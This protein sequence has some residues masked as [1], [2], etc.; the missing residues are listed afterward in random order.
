MPLAEFQAD[1]PG[2]CGRLRQ[3][4]R[5]RRWGHAYL[6]LGDD[7][8][9]LERFARAWA[10]ACACPSPAADGDACGTCAVCRGLATDGYPDLHLLR[11]RSKSRQIVVDDVREFER[12]LWLTGTTRHPKVGL[13]LEADRLNVQGQNAFLKTLEEPTPNTLLL[14][15]STNPKWLLPTVRSRCQTIPLMRNRR[16]Y[17]HL[18]RMGLFPILAG[19]QPEAGAAAALQATYGLLRILDRL[20]QEA[21]AE[22]EAQAPAP[23]A[24]WQ[25]LAREDRAIRKELEERQKA[26]ASAAYLRRRQEVTDAILVWF[27]LQFLRAA[28]GV[29]PESLPHPEIL[30]AAGAGAPPAVAGAERLCRLA[31]ELVRQLEGN[32]PDALAVEAFCLEACAR[33]APPR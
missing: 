6:F 21:E 4:A 2:T 25:E 17:A 3:V 24:A 32:L 10:Q 27:E 22:S 5:A 19:I 12:E 9:Y 8:D 23:D 28:G 33:S 14:L 20:R 11:P 31:A 18:C 30:A 1:F 16:E 26:A 13:F 29:A 15:T 7:A